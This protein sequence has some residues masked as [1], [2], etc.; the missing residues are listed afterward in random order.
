MF[1][2]V[3]DLAWSRVSRETLNKAA[4]ERR[5]HEEPYKT[6]KVSIKLSLETPIAA[7]RTQGVLCNKVEEFNLRHNYTPETFMSSSNI[8]KL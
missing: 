8:P 7:L 6:Y 5:D 3:Y 1:Y 2:S 4:K